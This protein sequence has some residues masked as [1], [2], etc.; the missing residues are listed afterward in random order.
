MFECDRTWFDCKPRRTQTDTKANR[1]CAI[2]VVCVKLK[3]FVVFGICVFVNMSG[4]DVCNGRLSHLRII[5][6]QTTARVNR[7]ITV[8]NMVSVAECRETETW[9]TN[10]EI[11][12]AESSPIEFS[13]C[14]NTPSLQIVI[15]LPKSAKN[16]FAVS[17]RSLI[18]AHRFLF[19][20]QTIIK[21]FEQKTKWWW[22]EINKQISVRNLEQRCWQRTI[23]SSRSTICASA[24]IHSLKFDEQ[25][26]LWVDRSPFADLWLRG[27]L[28]GIEKWRLTYAWYD[29]R[30]DGTNWHHLFKQLLS[31][32]LQIIVELTNA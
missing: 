30:H 10:G 8:S 23:N 17:Y 19:T 29:R 15:Y 2:C 9:K 24:P 22:N 13:L 1:N 16:R 4:L 32:E 26:G 3:C 28:Y 31:F 27:Q 7:Q 6:L 25:I 21:S 14:L 5:Y 11:V 18:L 20:N 12:T